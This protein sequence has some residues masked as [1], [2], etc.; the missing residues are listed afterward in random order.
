M[1]KA[2]FRPALKKTMLASYLQ[3]FSRKK[4]LQPFIT[5]I[6]NILILYINNKN[7]YMPLVFNFYMQLINSSIFQL[8]FLSSKC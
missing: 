2:E 1:F 4:L 6:P 5:K 7:C 8:P 3:K